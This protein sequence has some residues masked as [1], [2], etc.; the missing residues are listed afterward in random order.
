[1]A[2]ASNKHRQVPKKQDDLLR[3]AV[4]E[5]ILPCDGDPWTAQEDALLGTA[6]DRVIGEKLGRS[7]VSVSNRRI[8]LEI[9]GFGRKGLR[10]RATS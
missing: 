5:F 9:P 4:P 2:T 3:Y 10:K 7:T 8:K 6:C 1:M